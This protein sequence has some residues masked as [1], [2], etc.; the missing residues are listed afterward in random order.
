MIDEQRIATIN[1]LLEQISPLN[2]ERIFLETS[3]HF[4]KENNSKN[5]NEKEK[6]EII[7]KEQ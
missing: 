1:E 5:Y 7:E 2:Y 6:T 3:L 4:S